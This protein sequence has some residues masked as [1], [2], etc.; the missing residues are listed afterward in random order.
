MAR[1]FIFFNGFPYSYCIVFFPLKKLNSH[2]I[3]NESKNLTLLEQLSHL[4]RSID[5]CV[6]FLEIFFSRGKNIHWKKEGIS[7]KKEKDLNLNTLGKEKEKNCYMKK[8]S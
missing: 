2:N 4:I 7:P 6:V 3:G 5:Y 8:D 1:S